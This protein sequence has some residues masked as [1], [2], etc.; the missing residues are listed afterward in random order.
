MQYSDS[1]HACVGAGRCVVQY[2]DSVHACVGLASVW[3]STVTVYMHVWGLGGV[4]CSTVTV[5]MHV[6]GIKWLSLYT[7]LSPQ[8][9]HILSCVLLVLDW[10]PV[11][12]HYT[13]TV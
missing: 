3:C 7:Q 1:V 2:S 10:I 13:A 4:W 5:Y 6:W 12:S 8:Y 11:C 9:A